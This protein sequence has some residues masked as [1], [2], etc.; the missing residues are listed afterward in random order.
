M[1]MRKLGAAEVWILDIGLQ[2]ACVAKQDRRA[3]KGAPA[4]GLE[5]SVEVEIPKH[6]ILAEE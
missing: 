1:P 3:V 2:D 4:L 5:T 6:H